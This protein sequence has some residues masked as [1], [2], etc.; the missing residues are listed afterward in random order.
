MQS[1]V[2]SWGA[3]CFSRVAVHGLL[4]AAVLLL[5]STGSGCTASV[6]AVCGLSSCS[7]LGLEHGL[8]SCGTHRLS[9][10]EA[11]GI[12]LDQESNLCLPLWQGDSLLLSH[13]GSPMTGYLNR[14]CV[15]GKAPGIG[16]GKP[17]QYSSLEN[18]MDR[19]AWQS[20][21]HGVAKS[22]TR[23]SNWAHRMKKDLSEAHAA[24]GKDA[25]H[26]YSPG[27]GMVSHVYD[28]DRVHIFC[29]CSDITTEWSYLFFIHYGHRLGFSDVNVFWSCLFSMGESSHPSWELEKAM[30]PHSS[31]LARKIPWVEEPGRLQSMGS[32]RV[33]HDWVTSL[34]LFTFIHWRRKWQPTPVFLPGEPQGRGSL[35]GCHLWGRTESDTTEAT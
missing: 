31:T 19:W 22:W 3:G 15:E 35:V 12:L 26:S 24:V 29:L 13:Q 18:S 34:S 2:S 20:T 27:W 7:S 16:N 25:S 5:Q 28:L 32:L 9:C 21:I 8:N 23:L 33:G 1:L 30:A 6:A 10:S 17:L 14:L 11:C 4:I